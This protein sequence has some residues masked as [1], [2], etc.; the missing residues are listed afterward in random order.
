M[1]ENKKITERFGRDRLPI[2]NGP[3]DEV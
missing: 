2:R 3:R 1:G